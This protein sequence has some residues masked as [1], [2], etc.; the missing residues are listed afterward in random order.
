MSE[1]GQTRIED[2]EEGPL[3]NVPRSKE[4]QIRW[5]TEHAALLITT[6]K[7]AI[8]GSVAG[9]CVGFGTKLFLWALEAAS[10]E[11]GHLDVHGFHY[12]YLLPLAFPLTVWII[13]TYAPSAK[14]HGT[15]AVIAAV[16]QRSGKID[17]VV[18]PVKLLA[19][20]ITLAFGGSAGKEGPC[21]QIGASITSLFADI[22]KLNDED[23]RRL[24]ICGIGAGFA[25]VFGTPISGAIFGIGVLYLGRIEYPVLFPCLI[26]GIIAHLVAGVSAP[27]PANM[28]AVQMGAPE[29]LAF[30]LLAGIVFGLVALMLIESM[31]GLE[32]FLHRWKKY[33]YAIAVVGGLALVALFRFAGDAYAGLGSQ[34]IEDTLAG[35]FT[36]SLAACVHKIVATSITLET[37]GSGGIVTPMFFIGS[38]AGAAFAHLMH[39][40]IGPFAAFGFVAVVAAGANT[41]IA[42]AIMAVELLP[43]STGVYAALC[44]C[45]AYLIVGHRSVYASQKLG[46]SKTPGLVV[47]LDIPIGDVTRKGMQ[48]QPGSITERVHPFSRKNAQA[49]AL[50]GCRALRAV[51]LEDSLDGFLSRLCLT[52]TMQ[53][54]EHRLERFQKPPTLRTARHMGQRIPKTKRTCS[55]IGNMLQ[56]PLHVPARLIRSAIFMKDHF[57][58]PDSSRPGWLMIGLVSDGQAF[59]FSRRMRRPRKRRDRIVPIGTPSDS[60]ASS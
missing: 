20:V 39:L 9:L 6:I 36:L 26:A 55:S 51:I 34:H 41:P 48:I 13:R 28:G 25:A 8:L 40:P 1:P 43:S 53:A 50:I 45:T 2:L 44:A 27:V 58:A 11:T 31:K 49:E 29:L 38:T 21:A 60:A 42:A 47:P 37:G 3:T 10:R 24:V 12:Y 7:W 54:S 19:T 35:L 17:W 46:Y 52:N 22:L 57:L 16:H 4:E 15:E 5:Y 59:S 23:R 32:R 18:A 14:G 30:T 33:P 56:M